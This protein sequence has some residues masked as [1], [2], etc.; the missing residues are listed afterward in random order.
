MKRAEMLKHIEDEIREIIERYNQANSDTKL[1]EHH[2][3]AGADAI[4]H[5]MIEFGP[6]H[7]ADCKCQGCESVYK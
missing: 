1:K 6:Q 2:I 7:G 5:M 4:F 3:N